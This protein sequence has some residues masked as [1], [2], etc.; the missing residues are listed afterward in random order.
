[1][2]R[3]LAAFVVCGM[4][5]TFAC[6]E[7]SNVQSKHGS[8]SG[9]LKLPSV[10]ANEAVDYPGIHNVVA[11]SEGIYSG[12]APE[13][14][15]AFDTLAKLGVKTIISVDGAVPE[16]DRAKAKGIR[17]VHLPISYGGID[18]DQQLAIARAVRD[19]DGPIYVHCH[20]GKH[21]SA[22]AAGSAAVILGRLT[23]EQAVERM[24]VSGTSPSYKGLYSCVATATVAN[25]ATLQQ[26][27]ADFPEITR[28]SGLVDSMVAIDH[29][30]SHLKEIEKAGWKAPPSHPDLV[31]AAEAGRLADLLRNLPD[32][33]EVKTMP[34]EFTTLLRRDA[35]K[36]AAFEEKLVAGNAD[37]ATLSAEF[38]VIAQSCKECHSKYRD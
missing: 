4:L 25:E 35:E 9:T 28:P 10:D 1:M 24:K 16:V 17:Y 7:F 29:A 19:L 38:R 12:S 11:F 3:V 13:D 37:A 23:P 32:D 15:T 8:S 36:V 27:R 14:D 22:G 26:A 6:Q 30:L 31:P 5:S 21:R 34:T 18:A 33:A 2:H 20:H